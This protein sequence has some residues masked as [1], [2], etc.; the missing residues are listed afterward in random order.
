M[1]ML[2]SLYPEKAFACLDLSHHLGL[3]YTVPSGAFP[4]DQPSLRPGAPFTSWHSSLCSAPALRQP[5]VITRLGDTAAVSPRMDAVF[6]A[7]ISKAKVK[8]AYF[9]LEAGSERQRRG[10]KQRAAWTGQ[11]R[12]L[13]GTVRRR[14]TPEITCPLTSAT[15]TLKKCL[16]PECACGS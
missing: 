11:V 5:G 7:H 12:V 2:L 1:G 8:G 15:P 3:H 16:E 4:D 9:S 13:P 14:A 6:P 10:R